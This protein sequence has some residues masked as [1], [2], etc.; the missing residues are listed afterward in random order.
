MKTIA[1]D[2]DEVL[3]P[4]FQD[5]INYYNRLY[6]TS[7]TLADNHPKETTNWGTDNIKE[8]VERVQKF[9]DTDEFKN[10]QPFNDAKDAVRKLA[11]NYRLIVVTSRDTIIEETTRN[12]LDQHFAE[13]F[14]EVHFT[15]MYSLDGAQRSKGEVSKAA[16]VD[17]LIDDSYD[18]I[19]EAAS[20]GIKGL[21]FGD[22]PWNQQAELVDGAIR[23]KDWDA[24]LAY[25]A[26]EA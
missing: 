7:L 22:Y 14:E 5:L 13:L 4:H 26:S 10:S 21:L 23:V 11:Q 19:A 12:W 18:H 24:V 8:A 6:G 16:K 1:I 25:F 20:H 17:W 3:L 15:S 2:I 9:F